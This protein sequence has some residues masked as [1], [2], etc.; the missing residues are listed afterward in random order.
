MSRE[1]YRRAHRTG[2]VS[3]DIFRPGVD[4]LTELAALATNDIWDGSLI[5]VRDLN[6][7]Y[8]Y[9]L[10]STDADDGLNVI[11][12]ATSVGRWLKVGFGGAGTGSTADKWVDV[13]K[14]TATE[15]VVVDKTSE[16]DWPQEV[17]REEITLDGSLTITDGYVIIG[18]QNLAETLEVY[19]Q[20]Q[21]HNIEFTAGDNLIM[22][23][24]APPTTG[25]GEGSFFVGDGSSGTIAGQPY[26]REESDGT[27]HKLNAGEES[28]ADT[29]AIG[30]TTGGTHI[31]L[32][33]ND[34]IQGQ[35]DVVIRATT[36]NNIDLIADGGGAVR[37]Y[38]DDPADAL[39]FL[40]LGENQET[41]IVH[42][43]VGGPFTPVNSILNF[44]Y[45]DLLIP[46]NVASGASTVTLRFA[47]I[48]LT[49]NTAGPGVDSGS[50]S[51]DTGA[52]SY[53]SPG[54]TAGSSGPITFST[55]QV[56]GTSPS[57]N[58]TGRT[59]NSEGDTG[60]ITLET[61]EATGS[62]V[63]SGSITMRSGPASSGSSGEI[64]LEAGTA[65]SSATRG[66]VSI[67]AEGLN[68]K[69]SDP[70]LGSKGSDWKKLVVSNTGTGY[71]T[72]GLYVV[73]SGGSSF[74]IDRALD[75][76]RINMPESPGNTVE[77]HG[78]VPRACRL[79][80]VEVMMTTLNTVGNLNLAVTT[81]GTS[82]LSGA[83][84]NLNGLSAANTVSSMGLT[85][86][87]S[88]RIFV[89]NQVW[90]ISLES[91]DIGMD[92]EGIYIQLLW[93]AGP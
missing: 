21:G 67:N 31:L 13:T 2:L 68:I 93:E 79:V 52:T 34:E 5:H 86:T 28:L 77:F 18:P 72:G 69:S 74:L 54:T 49:T 9:D 24:N 64:A 56:T 81:G 23:Q 88:D 19:N 44:G 46:Q 73:D 20:T 50:V 71:T 59:G 26:F 90:K 12:P 35:T 11:T 37:I 3:A 39:V 66:T 1:I 63:T 15:S 10:E 57:G 27:V 16:D 17:V 84:Y 14:I 6:A 80:S 61:G 40:Q 87:L 89:G 30:N 38:T 53:V 36:D 45:R 70:G 65:L 91:T 51:I 25:A 8:A 83:N 48:P 60:V 92:G 78:W 58:L 47:S 55:G 75:V 29:L 85:A 33:T 22:P 76:E 32:S 82:L 42:V 62:N 7:I 43:P 4:D 41:G